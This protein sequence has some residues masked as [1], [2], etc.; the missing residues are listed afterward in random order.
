MPKVETESDVD[1]Q[2]CIVLMDE[3]T[4]TQG[5]VCFFFFRNCGRSGG[6]RQSCK[7]VFSSNLLNGR[8]R[9]EREASRTRV[10]T[11]RNLWYT[12]GFQRSTK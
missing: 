2:L 1:V 8:I 5:S 7:N 4:P 3:F 6:K 9:I 12:R 11:T 10:L